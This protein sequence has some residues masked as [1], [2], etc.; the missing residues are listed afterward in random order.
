MHL[1]ECKFTFTFSF[2]KNTCWLYNE[3]I[4][5]VTFKDIFVVKIKNEIVALPN[6]IEDISKKFSS[7]Q[8]HIKTSNSSQ[9]SVNLIPGHKN[10][11]C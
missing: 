2:D 11:L 5:Y 8:H 4:L 10:Q 7:A 1:F 6:F 3:K 9:K